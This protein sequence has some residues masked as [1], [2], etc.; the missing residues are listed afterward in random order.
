MCNIIYDHHFIRGYF[1]GDGY[2]STPITRPGDCTLG[3]TSN[4]EFLSDIQAILIEN[5]NINKTKLSD[6][7][8]S[9]NNIYKLMYGGI[10]NAK[11]IYDFLYMDATLFLIR[12]KEKFDKFFI[13]NKRRLDKK[14]TSKFKNVCYDRCRSKWMG[15]I[16]KNG[17]IISKRFSL[18]NDA[19]LFSIGNGNRK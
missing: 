19:Y 1:D 12:K 17:Q 14:K 9:K 13:E 10:K 8:S 15:Y 7:C 6:T 4:R 11:K 5:T 16:R 18:E 2:L 3:I